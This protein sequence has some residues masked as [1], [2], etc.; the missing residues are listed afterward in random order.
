MGTEVGRGG[1]SVDVTLFDAALDGP[2]I[3]PG[4]LLGDCG[5]E[6]GLY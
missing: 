5:A 2:P 4:W 3:A 6:V 1:L